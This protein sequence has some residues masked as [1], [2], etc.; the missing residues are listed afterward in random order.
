[1]WNSGAGMNRGDDDGNIDCDDGNVR[2][3]RFPNE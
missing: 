3:E 1:M 2:K